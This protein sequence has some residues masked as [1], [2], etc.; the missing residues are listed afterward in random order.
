MKLNRSIFTFL[1]L[2]VTCPGL[3]AFSQGITAKGTQLL[4]YYNHLDVEHLWLRGNAINWQSGATTGLNDSA[5]MRYGH[6][7][8]FVAAV[9]KKLKVR[10]PG[11]DEC[12][13]GELLVNAQYKWMREKGKKNGWE[14]KWRDV[15][16][17]R[18]ANEGHLVI[19][20]YHG[21]T[22]DQPGH[23]VLVRPANLEQ[24]MIEVDGVQVIQAG[25]RNF[26]SNSAREGFREFPQAFIDLQIEFYSHKID[27]IK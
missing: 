1:L 18:L 23:I 10:F 8:E 20:I 16:A 17:Q 15:D 6:A 21:E 9:C 19:G 4:L 11:P 12:I 2:S 22:P 7:A 25:A 24:E 3:P 5:S 26:T 27:A 14:G 13:K